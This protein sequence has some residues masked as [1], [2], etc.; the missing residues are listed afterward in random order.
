MSDVV[1]TGFPPERQSTVQPAVRTEPATPAE[2]PRQ[3]PP[4]AVAPGILAPL[5]EI[6]PCRSVA[7]HC[8]HEISRQW[9]TP[10]LTSTSGSG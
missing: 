6:T 2:V 1:V 8:S 10:P 5:C 9:M 4:I 3:G 7:I